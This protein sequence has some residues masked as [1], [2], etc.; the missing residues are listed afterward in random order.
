MYNS[1]YRDNDDV[2]DDINTKGM[3]TCIA[4]AGFLLVAVGAF[5]KQSYLNNKKLL[6]ECEEFMHNDLQKAE[7]LTKGLK[8]DVEVRLPLSQ[9]QLDIDQVSLYASLRRPHW[10]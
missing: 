7:R 1:R 3:K 2:D 5:G 8:C 6:T 10:E 4:L 9:K